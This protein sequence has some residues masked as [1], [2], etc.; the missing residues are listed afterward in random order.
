M[1]QRIRVVG[2]I[3]NEDGVLI[4]KRHRGR[5]EAPVFWE[6][7]TVKISFGEQP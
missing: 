4:F 5:S 1:K 2:I 6:L 3:R 7:P